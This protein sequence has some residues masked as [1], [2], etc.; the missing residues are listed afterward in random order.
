MVSPPSHCKPSALSAG[1]PHARTWWS[2]RARCVPEQRS[3]GGQSRSLAV[4]APADPQVGRSA[5]DG[6]TAPQTSQ[7]DSAGSIP[8]TRS[9]A[10]AQVRR[11]LWP[12]CAVGRDR[13]TVA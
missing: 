4:S 11:V 8:V 1:E 7:A 9:W 2:G 3:Q 5:G 6:D 13:L 12:L 10:Y